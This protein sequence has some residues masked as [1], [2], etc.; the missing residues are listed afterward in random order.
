MDDVI[1][2]QA[3]MDLLPQDIRRALCDHEEPP[4]LYRDVLGEV[5][6]WECY[7]CGFA[8]RGR[9]PQ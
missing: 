7:Q 9:P 3:V 1:T 6:A 2:A 8:Q 4:R 5:W